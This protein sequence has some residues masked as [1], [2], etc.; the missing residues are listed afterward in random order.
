MSRNLLQLEDEEM[1]EKQSLYKKNNVMLIYVKNEPYWNM[2]S[3]L[4][5]YVHRL[6]NEHLNNVGKYRAVKTI[7]LPFRDEFVKGI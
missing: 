6:E 1:R 3:F 5:H 4:N 2:T 7:P